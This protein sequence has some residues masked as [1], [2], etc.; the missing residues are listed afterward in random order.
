MGESINSLE[1][2][3]DANAD[4]CEMLSFMILSYCNYYDD[5]EYDVI[6]LRK[7]WCTG[8]KHENV[9]AFISIL[10]RPL[11]LPVSKTSFKL[12]HK[13]QIN[14]REVCGSVIG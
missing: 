2:R 7:T 3:E 11:N 4:G 13:S 12:D 6:V 14:L 10:R 8:V 5:G 9:I 1:R